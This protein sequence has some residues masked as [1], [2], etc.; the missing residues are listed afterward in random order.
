MKKRI[1]KSAIF[2]IITGAALILPSCKKMLIVDSPSTIP[3]DVAFASLS[4][5]NSTLIGVYN[6]LIGDNGYGERLSCIF[7]QCADD[8]KTSGS[9][10]STDRRGISLYGAT[11]DNTELPNPFAQLYAG[12]ERAN[13]CIK[14]IPLSPL[15][16]SGS[17]SDK[18]TMQQ[19]YGE[20]LALRAQFYYVLVCNWGDVV[21][22]FIPSADQT[23]FDVPA[24]KATV[25]LDQLL[26]DLQIAENMVPWRTESGYTD[27]R[28]TKGAI[29]GL[30]ARIALKR[31]GYLLNTTDHMMERDPQYLNYYKIAM[32]ECADVMARRDENDLNPVYENIFKTLHSATRYDPTN[33]LMFEVGAFGGNSTTDSKLGYYNGLRFSTSSTFGG[34]GGGITAI[35]TYF[36]EFDPIGDCRRDVTLGSYDIDANSMKILNA[37]NTETDAKFRRSWS[38]VIGGTAQNFGINWPILRFADILLMYAEAYNEVYNGPNAGPAPTAT[39]ALMEVRTR[40][41][42]GYTSRIPVP[43][44]DHD[45]FFSQDIVHERLLEFGGEGIRK[46][47]LIRWNMLQ[48]KFDE[49]R[50]KLRA[51]IAGTG[52]YAN[53]PLYV[54]SRDAAYQQTTSTQEVA[55]IDTYGGPPSTTLFSPGSG[56]PTAP[57]G[58]TSIKWRAAVTEA[59]DVSG[60]STG[61]GAYFIQNQREV[62]PFPASVLLLNTKLKQNYGYN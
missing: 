35:A 58:Y 6:Q 60:P 2:C 9:Y 62:F 22:P 48:S 50:T 26:G 38:I 49:T 13:I 47:D 14:G 30:R 36:Y 44:T 21:A 11:S 32:S 59:G 55:T 25:I 46:Y 12:I 61:I 33:E 56:S 28:W 4:N 8:F 42:V 54:Y 16:T 23:I 43:Y 29:K 17:A 15:Y 20:A 45:N 51:L 31:G 37:L 1:I 39:S 34:G 3:Q 10:A 24:T 52:A 53:V 5:T 27:T 57:A 41:Y 19:Y 18:A 7:T 40:A